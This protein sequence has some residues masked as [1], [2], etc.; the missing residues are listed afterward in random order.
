MTTALQCPS[1]GDPVASDDDF[2]EACGAR[3]RPPE[4]AEGTCPACGAPADQADA[5][6][7]CGRC[8]TRLPRPSDHVE[9][10]VGGVV[11]VTDKGLRHHRNEDAGALRSGI[12]FS[13]LV[14]C[15]G[16][17]TTANPD[18]AS[19][20]A[21]A[22]VAD[23]V[24]A[25]LAGKERPAPDEVCGILRDAIA[26]GQQ[27]V[28]GVPQQ[29]SGGYPQA[30]SS[31]LVA[32]VVVAETLVCAN[33]GDSRAYW[34]DTSE[35]G[36]SRQLSKDDSLAEAAIAAGESPESAYARRDAHTI[37]HWL[38]ADAPELAPNVESSPAGCG[39]LVVC[40]DG[41]WNYF[42]SP[43]TLRD[44]VVSGP[45]DEKPLDRARRLVDAA[46][47]AGGADNITVALTPLG[48][49]APAPHE[50]P[51]AVEEPAA[52]GEPVPAAEPSAT[53]ETAPEP[54]PTAETGAETK[55]QP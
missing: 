3:L 16:V 49:G 11:L 26:A 23:A 34:I 10:E 14:V 39:V 28:L 19:A 12:G 20:A 44:L 27:A 9:V 36:G 22:A 2:C 35:G 29:E 52:I 25:A 37:T 47:A 51:A 15:D 40:S 8:G 48:A 38:G 55:E 30:P 5:D 18:Q 13:A 21:A 17:S 24:D 50:E 53:V 46:I 45:P 42:E 33:V 4:P 43:A 1:C 32:V 41:L 6:G 7:Y 54:T 31:T